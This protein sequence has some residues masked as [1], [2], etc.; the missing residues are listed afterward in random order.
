MMS[1]NKKTL[2]FVAIFAALITG[3]YFVSKKLSEKKK[4]DNIGKEAKVL[5][6]LKNSGGSG[7]VNFL[8]TLHD[9]YIDAWYDAVK[10]KAAYFN[11]GGGKFDAV[12][13]K[14]RA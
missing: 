8:I 2:I 14:A 11:S 13:G 7:D 9:D 6:I 1:E 4:D 10:N 5:F 3:A 12:T